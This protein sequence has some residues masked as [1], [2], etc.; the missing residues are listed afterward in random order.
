MIAYKG[1]NADLTCTMGNGKY[2]YEPNRW[3]EEKEA[4]CVKNGFHCAADP[5]D[6]MD[7]Y[8]DWDSSQYWMVQVDG[9]IDEDGYNTKISATRIRLLRR[10]NIVEFLAHAVSYICEHPRLQMNRRVKTENC[11]AKD[12]DKFLIV[13]NGTPAAM[14]SKAGQY[15]VLLKDDEDGKVQAA[16]LYDIDGKNMF[17]GVWYNVEGRTGCS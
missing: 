5:L 13:R 10:L 11:K 7:Y 9:D 14:A 16:G 4:N 17:P 2:Q 8:G 6:C 3:F 1:F 12:T 15:L